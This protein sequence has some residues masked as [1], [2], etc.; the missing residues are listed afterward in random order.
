MK[1]Q[2]NKRLLDAKKAEKIAV[3]DDKIKAMK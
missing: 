1:K 2:E 3:R